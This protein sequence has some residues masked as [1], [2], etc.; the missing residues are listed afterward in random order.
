MAAS[1]VLSPSVGIVAFP[2]DA[3]ATA[4]S[5]MINSTGPSIS[6]RPPLMTVEGVDTAAAK[7]PRI[8]HPEADTTDADRFCAGQPVCRTELYGP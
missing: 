4:V 6:N 8:A 2:D 5:L 3:S 7:H 1:K